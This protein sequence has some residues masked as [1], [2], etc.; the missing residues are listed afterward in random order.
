MKKALII[1]FSSFFSLHYYDPRTGRKYK[2][3]GHI[4][5]GWAD[6]CSLAI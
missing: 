6:S 3:E 4:K 5:F 2:M 1:I